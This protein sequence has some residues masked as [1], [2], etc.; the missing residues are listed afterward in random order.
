GGTVAQDQRVAK[1]IDTLALTPKQSKDLLARVHET[2]THVTRLVQTSATFQERLA[3]SDRAA[4][5]LRDARGPV[6]QQHEREAAGAEGGAKEK[7][8]AKVPSVKPN[9]SLK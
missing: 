4:G 9:L 5:V 1:L 7:A 8:R 3:R 6:W 2:N